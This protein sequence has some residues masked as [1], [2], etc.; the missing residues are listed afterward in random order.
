MLDV[1]GIDDRQVP[2]GID[3]RR[4]VLR[5]APADAYTAGNV[6]TPPAYGAVPATVAMLP[7]PNVRS[8]DALR[9]WAAEVWLRTSI[10]A[11]S[12]T[13]REAQ[14]AWKRIAALKPRPTSQQMLA[15]VINAGPGTSIAGARDFYATIEAMRQQVRTA[16]GERTVSATAGSMARAIAAAVAAGT[17]QA[18]D[19]ARQV[20]STPATVATEGR[21]AAEAVITMATTAQREALATAR[22]IAAMPGEVVDHTVDAVTGVPRH[23]AEQA[24][25]VANQTLGTVRQLGTR[26]IDSARQVAIEVGPQLEPTKAIAGITTGVLVAGGLAV[27]GLG[28]VFAGPTI[29]N[30]LLASRGRR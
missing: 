21:K 19:V 6:S 4:L 15:D 2:A 29:A 13:T 17:K 8:P 28:A 24:A 26:F 14:D 30:N 10:A 12:W 7:A 22:D 25:G 20:V 9:A 11:G 27:A 16:T 3:L 1:F 18:A 23:L 5:G